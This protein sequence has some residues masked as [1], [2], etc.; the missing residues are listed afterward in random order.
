MER[1]EGSEG[2]KGRDDVGERRRGLGREGDG[3]EGELIDGLNESVDFF[4][5]EL[6]SACTEMVKGALV[7][8]RRTREEAGKRKLV[9][10][11][12]CRVEPSSISTRER[13][14]K[15]T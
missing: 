9:N 12:A 11:D 14:R 2:G 6:N 8:E 5:M 1:W 15:G 3:A 10:D 13:E 4:E 7:E